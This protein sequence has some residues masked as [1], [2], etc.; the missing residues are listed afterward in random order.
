[1]HTDP[2]S[3][4]HI[5]LRNNIYKIFAAMLQRRISKDTEQHMRKTQYGFR[6]GK[7]TRHP[8]FILRRGMEWSTMQNTILTLLFLDWKQAFDSI[9]H[10]LRRF[11]IPENV[12][13]AITSLYD[14]HHLQSGACMVWKH[15][16]RYSRP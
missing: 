8:M 9:D 5:S 3:Y 10:A 16:E 13:T 1:M 7:G 12:L 15:K 6:P 14:Y 4:R 2:A 11:G